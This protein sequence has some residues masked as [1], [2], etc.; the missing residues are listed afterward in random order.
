[1]A[2]NVTRHGEYLTQIERST[3]LFPINCYLVRE[4]DGLTLVD[5]NWMKTERAILDAARTLNAPIRR[6]ALT[7]VHGDHI[8]SLTALH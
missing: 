1:M 3:I 4:D 2:I 5:T 6:I 7:H 8:G